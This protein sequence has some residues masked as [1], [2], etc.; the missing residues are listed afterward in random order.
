M[1]RTGHGSTAVG[2]HVDALRDGLADPLRDVCAASYDE[3]RSQ[4]PD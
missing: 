3:M 1:A 2:E 4:L